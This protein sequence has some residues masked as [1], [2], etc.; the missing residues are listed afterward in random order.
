MFASRSFAQKFSRNTPW[1]G[2]G[3]TP[4]TPWRVL[5]WVVFCSGVG[6]VL[7]VTITLLATCWKVSDVSVEGS[8]FHDSADI[9]DIANIQNGDLMLGFDAG[10][11]ADAL[12]TEYPIL[13]SV[14]VRRGLNGH[15]TLQVKEHEH[16]YYTCHHMN[17]Y[18]ISGNNMKVLAISSTGDLYA[19]YGA[20]YLGFPEEVSLQV[21][22]RVSFAFLPYQPDNRPEEIFTYEVETG[23]PKE[24]YAYVDTLRETLEGSAFNAF[25]DGLDA[26]DRF[27]LYFVFNDRIMVKL[28]SMEHL[29]R[30]LEQ[31]VYIVNNELTSSEIPA[32]IDVS[33]PAKST[34][35][36]NPGLE[37]PNWCGN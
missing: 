3:S 24:E 35:R 25:L 6:M 12:K 16:L 2:K 29:E 21:G 4:V 9:L 27:D 18:L 10:D 15:V 8:D 26:S 20:V 14:K 30:K 1:G 7:A 5:F 11:V 34:L 31:A 19:A 17:Y 33:N 22:K 23:S 32:V 36:Q 28:G 37:M 13:S